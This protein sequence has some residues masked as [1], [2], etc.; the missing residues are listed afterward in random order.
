MTRPIFKGRN[1]HIVKFIEFD[2]TMTNSLPFLIDESVNLGVEGAY[3]LKY[4][5]INDGQINNL[6]VGRIELF[7]LRE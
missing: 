1:H 6:V 2:L 3:G 7:I 4:R 5:D